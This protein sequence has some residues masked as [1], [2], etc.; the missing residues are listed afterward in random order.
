MTAATLNDLQRSLLDYRRSIYRPTP[1][2]TVVEWCE[3]N[4]RLTTRQTEHPGPFSTAVRPYTREVL[5]CFKDPAVTDV[6]LCWG[7]QTAKT[8]S[9]MA[10]LAWLIDNEPSPLLWLMPTESLARSFAKTRWLPM[11]ADSP[12]M[13]RHFPD[14]RHKLTTLEQHFD[15]CTLNFV[16]SN[17]PANL[18]SRPIRVLVADEVDKFA[19]ATEREAA[20]LDLAMQR[21]KSFSSSKHFL[22]STPTVSEG[23]I[24]QQFLRGDQRRYFIPCPHCGEKIRLEWKQ[25]KWETEKDE[26][27]KTNLAKVRSSARYE[28]QLCGKD[29]SD[30]HKV[31]ALR[32]GEWRPENPSAIPGVR[33]Y[34]LSSLYSP[35]RKCTWGLL[36]VAFL[37]AKESLSTLALQGF[38]N[39]MLA[40]PWEN[41][42][43]PAERTEII[44]SSAEAIDQTAVKFL[45]VDFQARAPFF[46]FV[47]RSWDAAGNSRAIDAGPLDT[48]QDIRDKQV[49]H[50]IH[51]THVCID[52]GYEASTVYA[53]CLRWGKFHQRSFKVPLFL[54]WM[55]S[56]GVPRRGWR[57]KKSGV[58][59]PFFLQGIDPRI[60][61]TNGAK[62]ELKLLEFATDTTKDILER[63]RRGQVAQR[64]EVADK[65]AT[66]EYWRHLDAERK[67]AKFYSN[68]G[69]TTYTWLP[70]SRKW[71]NHLFDSEVM[72]VAM[73]VFHNRLRFQAAAENEQPAP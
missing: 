36:A 51:D 1:K 59:V 6:V 41:Q 43:A 4:L 53:E 50:D 32:A 10:G 9:L 26:A 58:E 67:V 31:A 28:C 71:P 35:D 16:G 29:I 13:V 39:G 63:I 24:W 20:A 34:H 46:W 55:P 27:G 14:D 61:T 22:T 66:P 42:G 64:W 48:W 60:G 11:L 12:T 19:Q 65:V 47:V 38:I 70:K 33:S 56:K 23:D 17:S 57:D 72:Q 37:E 7:S 44:V 2:K 30:A 49:E 40:E 18:A 8:M 73:A 68:S 25:V 54:G 21:T 45:T 69:R 62:L 5:E 52:S 15:H 3:E